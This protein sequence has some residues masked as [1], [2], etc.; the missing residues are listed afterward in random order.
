MRPPERYAPRERAQI[1]ND[2][3]IVVRRSARSRQIAKQM[4]MERKENQQQRLPAANPCRGCNRNRDHCAEQPV[5][6][7][8]MIDRI[9][10]A[11]TSAQQIIGDIHSQ[12]ET[13]NIWCQTRE[14][15][16]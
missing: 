4:Q 5:K 10:L 16:P 6:E 7:E 11:D 14:A 3:D 2:P 15:D 1:I 9:P 12:T 13:I 8:V